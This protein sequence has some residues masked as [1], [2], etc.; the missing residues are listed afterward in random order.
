VSSSSSS[1]TDKTSK[2]NVILPEVLHAALHIEVLYHDLGVP[3]FYFS[4]PGSAGAAGAGGAGSGDEDGDDGGG[5]ASVGPTGPG[6]PGD[7]DMSLLPSPSVIIET[8][9]ATRGLIHIYVLP[10]T[11]PISSTHCGR[12][13]RL[14]IRI[15]STEHVIT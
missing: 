15:N 1:S 4:Q 7:A 5:G 2:R 10:R 14:M 3:S 13:F 6:V 12:P 11:L 9:A 8:A